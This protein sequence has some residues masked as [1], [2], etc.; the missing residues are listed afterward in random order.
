MVFERVDKQI[1]LMS[2]E[3]NKGRI[4]AVPVA[5]NDSEDNRICGY[6]PYKAVC[7]RE[8]SAKDRKIRCDKDIKNVLGIIE[9]ERGEAE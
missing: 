3:L 6:C 9:Q 4:E 5:E 7:A 8:R 2:D 1:A